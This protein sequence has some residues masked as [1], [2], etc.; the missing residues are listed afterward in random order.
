MYRQTRARSS[1]KPTTTRRGIA[2]DLRFI[3]LRE[4]NTPSRAAVL[5]GLVVMIFDPGGLPAR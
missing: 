5:S 2:S 1:R 3:P 4:K